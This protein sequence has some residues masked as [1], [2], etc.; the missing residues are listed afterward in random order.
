MILIYVPEFS[1][2]IKYTFSFIFEKILGI[3]FRLTNCSN[4]F[5]NESSPKFSYSFSSLK[6]EIHFSSCN[7][8]FETDI[9]SQNLIE[10][11]NDPFATTF[12]LLSRYEEYLPYQ[13]DIHHRFSYKA[14]LVKGKIDPLIPWIDTFA[15]DLFNQLKKKFPSLVYKN[16]KFT[17]IN[18]IDIDH[19]W[20]YKNKFWFKNFKSLGKKGLTFR[21]KD[22][23]HQILVLSGLK[24]DPYFIYPYIQ[25]LNITT[26]Y[27]ISFGLGGRWDTNHH[28]KNIAYRKLICQ[29]YNQD[30]STIGLHPSYESNKDFTI[31][32]ME[33]LAL[34]K[35]LQQKI[36]FSRQHFIK[37][38]LPNTYYNLINLNISA[39]FSMGFQDHIGFRAGTCT[40]FY[41]FDLKNNKIS[42]LK[43]FPFCVMD[44]TL[45]NYMKLS[46]EEA[47]NKILNLLDSVKKVNGTFIS[48][49]HNDSLSNYGEW[50]LWRNVYE[51]LIFKANDLQVYPQNH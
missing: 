40:P 2:R 26:F 22:F 10:I 20:L 30:Y 27:F 4:N 16:R 36:S 32:K 51:K 39:D 31:L 34:E 33:K 48:I 35:L 44:V 3:S 28:P 18:T 29:L 14:S 15:F 49:F 11:L 1:E 17:F 45:K 50:K 46:I 13:G 19:A 12:F 6:N 5:I 24:L 9:K 41:W 43:I 38:H 21:W 7:L 23:Y 42:E 25:H 8:L 47:E 37:L